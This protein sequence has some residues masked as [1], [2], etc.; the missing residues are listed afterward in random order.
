MHMD[1]IEYE[2]YTNMILMFLCVSSC[3]HYLN[4]IRSPIRRGSI[5]NWRLNNSNSLSNSVKLGLNGEKVFFL[6]FCW[7]FNFFGNSQSFSMRTLYN[8]LFF[9]SCTKHDFNMIITLEKVFPLR[10]FTDLS[11]LTFKKWEKKL[12]SFWWIPSMKTLGYV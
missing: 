6:F 1:C 11:F 2:N 8:F 7:I 5:W 12:K 10:Y 4:V 9:L 3:Q